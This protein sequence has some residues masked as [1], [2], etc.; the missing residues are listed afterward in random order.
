[1]RIA[2]RLV[3]EDVEGGATLSE[4]MGKH[5]KAFDK[6]YTNMVA[7]GEAG[8]VLDVVLRRLADFMEYR[9]ME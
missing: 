5:P 8:G 7:A 3:A 1:L 6:L 4:A 9:H 2:V